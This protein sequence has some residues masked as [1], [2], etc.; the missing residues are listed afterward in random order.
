MRNAAPTPL[1]KADMAQRAQPW[2]N[3]CPHLATQL[4]IRDTDPVETQDVLFDSKTYSIAN[5]HACCLRS[6]AGLADRTPWK[7]APMSL[8]EKTDAKQLRRSKLG[9]TQHSGIRPV[10]S[11]QRHLNMSEQHK[12]LSGQSMHHAIS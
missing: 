4:R 11:S 7:Q 9:T 6:F 5:G 8:G 10:V 2:T 1:S 3:T 12:R